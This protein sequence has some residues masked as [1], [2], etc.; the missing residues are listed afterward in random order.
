MRRGVGSQ[1]IVKVAAAVAVALIVLLALAQILLPHLA[2]SRISSRVG[3]YG[4]VE[5][6]SVSAWPAVKLLWGDA[7]SVKVTAGRLSM[8]PT[9]AA[10]MMWEG[11]GVAKMDIAA[12]EVR[13]GPLAVTDAKMTKH[14]AQLEAQADTT[15][16]A[17]QAALGNGIGVKLLGSSGGRVRVS[18]AG[19]LFG[20]GASLPAVAEAQ[21]GKLIAHPEGLLIEGVRLTVFSDPHVHVEGVG[22]SVLKP[23]PLTYRLSMSALLG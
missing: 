21:D 13:V 10:A 11:R 15:Q 14:G 5:H 20:V 9:Q 7:D 23:S 16:T 12:E 17:A 19:S 2:A 1:T 3:R 18:V 4:H 8:S 22:A 6:V